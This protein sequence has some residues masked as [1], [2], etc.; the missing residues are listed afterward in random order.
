MFIVG[1]IDKC[2]KVIYFLC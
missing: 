2:S 1:T